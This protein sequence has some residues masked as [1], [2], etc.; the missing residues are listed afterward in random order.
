MNDELERRLLKLSDEISTERFGLRHYDKD[1]IQVSLRQWARL[2]ESDLSYRRVAYTQIIDP[3]NVE[4][5]IHISTVWIGLDMSFGWGGPPLIF[6]TMV[7]RDGEGCEMDRWSTLK[8]AKEGHVEMVVQVA[9]SI[10][11]AITMDA[12]EGQG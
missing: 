6:E 4:K 10:P 2:T 5:D 12:E 9:S 7:F 3:K 8:E 1:G 11:D